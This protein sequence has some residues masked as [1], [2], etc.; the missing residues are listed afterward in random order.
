MIKILA[1]KKIENYTF[2]VVGNEL[3]NLIVTVLRDGEKPDNSLG[4]ENISVEENGKKI[5]VGKKIIDRYPILKITDIDL[6]CEKFVKEEKEKL[7]EQEKRMSFFQK[8]TN[9]RLEGKEKFG[10]F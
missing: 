4:G 5:H 8:M 6:K 7:A 3:N 1:R 10:W 2:F 9:E